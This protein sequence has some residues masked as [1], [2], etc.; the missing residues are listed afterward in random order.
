M[1]NKIYTFKAKETTEGFVSVE[2][3]DLE[4]AKTIAH[5]LSKHDIAIFNVEQGAGELDIDLDSGHEDED[6]DDGN[7]LMST[8]REN[9]KENEDALND[10]PEEI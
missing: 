10:Y 4:L 5:T 2:A 8:P 3:P 7:H 9:A 1:T 6:A